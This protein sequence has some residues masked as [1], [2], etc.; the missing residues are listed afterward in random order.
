MFSFLAK[1]GQQGLV[2]NY[3]AGLGLVPKIS[4]YNGPRGVGVM[5]TC[6]PGKMSK[7]KI[8]QHLHANNVPGS[9]SRANRFPVINMDNGRLSN[10]DIVDKFGG[11]TVVRVMN[12]KM[13]KG[14]VENRYSCECCGP[15]YEFIKH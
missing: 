13:E 12:G 9:V 11:K 1:S 10:W 8:D 15:Y 7:R 14:H 3:L 4:N 6:S 2:A 5:V